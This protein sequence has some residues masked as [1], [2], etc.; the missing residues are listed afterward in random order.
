MKKETSDHINIKMLKT[1]QLLQIKI[2]LRMIYQSIFS[3]LANDIVG[4]DALLLTEED[5]CNHASVVN[6]K[7]NYN[8][9]L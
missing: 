5:L 3:T 2:L 8:M 1:T 4:T 7:N 6:I 9:Q